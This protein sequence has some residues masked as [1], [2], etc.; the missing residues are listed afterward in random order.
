MEI[1]FDFLL[2]LGCFALIA[3]VVASLGRDERRR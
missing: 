2:G 1:S 3:F